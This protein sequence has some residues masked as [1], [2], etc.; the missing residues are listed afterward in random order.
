MGVWKKLLSC[1]CS[2]AATVVAAFQ[3]SCN[4]NVEK[5]SRAGPFGNRQ[6]YAGRGKMFKDV[7]GG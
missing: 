5:V 6:Q 2:K 4:Y 3:Q 7:K 1:Y